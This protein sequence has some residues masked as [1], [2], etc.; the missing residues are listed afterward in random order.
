MHEHGSAEAPPSMFITQDWTSYTAEDHS[1]W[2]LLYAR[3]MQSL[4]QTGSRLFLEGADAIG[5]RQDQVPDLRKEL[6]QML[7]T[8]DI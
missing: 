3:R 7:D 8:V 2:S 1:V 4:A 6:G 5:L